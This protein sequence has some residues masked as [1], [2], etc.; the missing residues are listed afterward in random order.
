MLGRGAVYPAGYES[1]GSFP[2]SQ[3]GHGLR[4]EATG[5]AAHS[6]RAGGKS[7]PETDAD[8][9]AIVVAWPDLPEEIR[10]GIV[11]IIKTASG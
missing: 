2:H 5:R 6:R 4:F 1:T 9:A 7:A 3:R 8:L 11:V 10:A